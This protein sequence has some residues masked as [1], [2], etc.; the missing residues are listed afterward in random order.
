M[1][2]FTQQK[3]TH[4]YKEQTYAYQKGKRGEDKLGVLN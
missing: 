1:N 4:V 3:Q 2:L